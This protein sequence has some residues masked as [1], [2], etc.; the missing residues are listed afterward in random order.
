MVTL[1]TRPFG[2]DWG[3]DPRNLLKGRRPFPELGCF[4][5]LDFGANTFQKNLPYDDL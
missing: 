5:G 1:S 2:V 3:F 4:L